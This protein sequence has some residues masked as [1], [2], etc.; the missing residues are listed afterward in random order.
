MPHDTL[1]RRSVAACCAAVAML[2]LL[3]PDG[4][5]RAQGRR[6]AADEATVQRL[7]QDVAFSLFVLT[8]GTFSSGGYANYEDS[9]T[10]AKFNLYNLPLRG[11]VNTALVGPVEL[12]F[13]LAYGEATTNALQSVQSS[14]GPPGAALASDRQF[15]RTWNTRFGVGRPVE[16]MPDLV[17]TPLVGLGY[18]HWNGKLVRTSV[19]DV[20]VPSGRNDVWVDALLYEAAAILEYRLRWRDLNFRPGVAVNYAYIGSVDGRSRTAPESGVPA[21]RAKA[22]LYGSSTVLRAALRVDGPLGFSVRGTD[23]RWQS[24]VSGNYETSN[25]GLFPWSLEMGVAVGAELDQIGRR[26]LGFDPGALYVGV[27][28]FIGE[29]LQGVRANF[30]FRF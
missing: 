6:V 2:A 1:R 24:F 7:Y 5:G 13:S 12:R 10:D 11:R 4:P 29:N 8:S 22:E 27:S 25:Y 15:L 3:I 28:Y 21:E 17:F 14:G 30:G 18:S 9:S 19:G 23:L 26:L 20:P 16:L